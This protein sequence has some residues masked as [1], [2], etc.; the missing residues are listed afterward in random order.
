MESYSYFNKGGTMP[1]DDTSR[2]NQLFKEARFHEITKEELEQQRK[3]F[4]LGNAILDNPNITRDDI[5]TAANRLAQK[6]P[7]LT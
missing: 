2:L 3:S 1:E 5:A 7:P 4:A 6:T